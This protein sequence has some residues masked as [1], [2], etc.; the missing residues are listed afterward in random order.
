MHQRGGLPDGKHFIA[1]RSGA[2]PNNADLWLMA[3]E[4]HLLSLFAPAPSNQAP[5]WSND[6]RTVLFTGLPSDNGRSLFRK[7]ISDSGQGERIAEWPMG[8]L[9]DWSR[10]GRSRCWYM[11]LPFLPGN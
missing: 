1:V 9:C 3:V 4:R 5:V 11:R 8:R 10:D 7:G 6:G 2:S